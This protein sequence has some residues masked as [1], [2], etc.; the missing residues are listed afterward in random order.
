[1][2]KNIIFIDL[3]NKCHS[4]IAESFAKHYGNGK[5]LFIALTH[6]HF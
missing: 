2:K 6:I 4:Q 1:M 5:Y 3:L